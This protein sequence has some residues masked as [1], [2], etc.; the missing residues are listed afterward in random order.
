MIYPPGA[1]G[2]VLVTALSLFFRDKNKTNPNQ[3][4]K[5]VDDPKEESPKS[6]VFV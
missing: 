3:K 1:G 4:K 2:S 6:D 5:M